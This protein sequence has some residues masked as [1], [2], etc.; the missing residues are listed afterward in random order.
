MSHLKKK[1]ILGI[2]KCVIA[3]D[4]IKGLIKKITNI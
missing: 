1:L 3:T 2:C 4:I